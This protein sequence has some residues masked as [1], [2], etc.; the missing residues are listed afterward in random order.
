MKTCKTP[1]GTPKLPKTT[2]R[3]ARRGTRIPA[4]IF[5]RQ[6]EQADRCRK[7]LEETAATL[8]RVE[9][10][11]ETLSAAL[12]IWAWYPF[13]LMDMIG[14]TSKTE[15]PEAKSARRR[16]YDAL[17]FAHH[18][19]TNILMKEAARRGLQP[20]PLYECA[21]VVQ[22]IYADEP[23]KFYEGRYLA[24]PVCM[25]KARYTL[26]TGQQ[27]ALR[28]GE[29]VFIDLPL[30]TEIPA[31]PDMAT[32]QKAVSGTMPTT[33]VVPPPF[34]LEEMDFVLL[35][36]LAK[37]SIRTKLFDLAVDTNK[38]Y[39]RHRLSP[40]LRFLHEMGFVDWPKKTRKGAA[41]TDK[42][43]ELVAANPP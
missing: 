33:V 10:S 23:W 32:L 36:R 3:A 25:G 17:N 29:A 22:E 31:A 43:R 39:D 8:K 24:W 26:P 2:P 42:G 41:I 14:H 37:C 38:D 21:R 16:A 9:R 13:V 1:K 35:R 5:A 27:E 18:H 7:W 6:V 28:A 12:G 11:E 19:A 34:A 4:E 15:S 20:H 40:R 30:A